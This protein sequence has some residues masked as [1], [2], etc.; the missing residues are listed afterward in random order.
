MAHKW[1]F[2]TFASLVLA[3]GARAQSPSGHFH[4]VKGKAIYFRV[5]QI[6]KVTEVIGGKK[7]E[8]GSKLNLVKR[9]DVQ[10]VDQGTATVR[11]SMTAMR[12]EQQRPN[13]EILRFDSTNPD[14]STP[15]LREQMSKFIGQT[16]AILRV[17]GQG[18]VL[19][20]IKGSANQYE[21]D[22]PFVLRL[23]TQNLALRLGW[24][25]S[26]TITLD[27]PLGTG[28][29]I[30]CLQKYTVTA[31]N[32]QNGLATIRM[33]TELKMP[34]AVAERM[35]LLQKQAAGEIVF[36]IQA[37]RVQTVNLQIDK[38][39]Q[40]HQ[41]EGSSYHFVSSYKEQYAE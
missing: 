21:S 32:E 13:G 39:L 29:K 1:L 22:P 37:G 28:E 16:L 38:T 14:K 4:W 17:D 23:P 9:W 36:N 10:E 6:T 2:T 25:R 3:A 24:E 20:V 34:A 12:H 7:T 31:I 41:G 40:G 15:E 18:K 30:P 26:Y 19:E 8:S 27:P 33:S 11:L 5:E 35:P